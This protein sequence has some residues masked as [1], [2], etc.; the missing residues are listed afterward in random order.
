VA[1]CST[2]DLLAAGSCLACL[3]EKQLDVVIVQLLREWLGSSPT[4][5]ELLASGKCMQCL[6]TKQIEIA[7]VQLL[8]NING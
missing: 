6:D 7:K 4:P 5:E 2:S 3:S 1:T 8:C